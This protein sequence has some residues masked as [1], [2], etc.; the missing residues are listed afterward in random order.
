MSY[1]FAIINTHWAFLKKSEVL[2]IEESESELLCTDSTALIFVC[3]I[4]ELIKAY[5]P[6]SVFQFGQAMQFLK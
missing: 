6:I 2:K 4:L 5:V 3:D 1:W